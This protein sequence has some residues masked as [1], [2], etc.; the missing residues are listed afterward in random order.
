MYTHAYKAIQHEI[1]AE[2]VQKTTLVN[3]LQLVEIFNPNINEPISPAQTN[4][5][6]TCLSLVNALLL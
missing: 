6:G 5:G 4:I 2:K 3:S 1:H